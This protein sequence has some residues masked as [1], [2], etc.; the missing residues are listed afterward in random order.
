MNP[1]I[2][3]KLDA[4]RAALEEGADLSPEEKK[5]RDSVQ[6]YHSVRLHKQNPFISGTVERGFVICFK[7]LNKDSEPLFWTGSG[8]K[9]MAVVR[10]EPESFETKAEAEKKIRSEI[11]DFIRKWRMDQTHL[12]IG[13]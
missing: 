10:S 8:F 13:W 2:N 3:E 11:L 4:M 6:K 7:T 12:I 9:N 1:T 5:E